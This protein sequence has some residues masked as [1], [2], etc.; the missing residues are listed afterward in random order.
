M[1]GCSLLCYCFVWCL[2]HVR[3]FATP[4]T[5]AHQAPLSV[6]FSRQECWMGSHFLLQRIFP[7]QG[8]N[9]CLLYCRQILYHWATR[10]ALAFMGISHFSWGFKKETII[11]IKMALK[12]KS[13]TC[14][15]SDLY[16]WP[17]QL[18]GFPDGA[19]GK[20]SACQSRRYR[21][22]SWVGKIPWRRKW[23]PAPVFLPD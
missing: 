4:R 2:R 12:W 22:D 19:S 9:W 8:L 6:G 5:V 15:L 3:R 17:K 23:Q 1:S 10:E 11:Y 13:I 14:S 18:W 16:S 20:E 21:F 7:T